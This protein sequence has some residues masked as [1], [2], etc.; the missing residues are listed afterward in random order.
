[1]MQEEINEW[2]RS[3]VYHEMF[4]KGN[5]VVPEYIEDPKKLKLDVPAWRELMVSEIFDEDET[6]VRVFGKALIPTP[7]VLRQQVD[8]A[9]ARV[10]NCVPPDG[11]DAWR[12]SGEEDHNGFE[13]MLPNFHTCGCENINAQ[14][15]AF[16]AG[17]N[18]SKKLSTALHFEGNSRMIQRKEERLLKRERLGHNNASK[19]HD[20]NRRAGHD[21]SSSLPKL[22]GLKPH[23]VTRPPP[24][25]SEEIC[26]RTIGPFD[27]E[28][29]KR[30]AL[31][32]D[33]PKLPKLSVGFH[34][35]AMVQP[36]LFSPAASALA[37]PPLALLPFASAFSPATSA[38][39]PLASLPSTLPTPSTSPPLASLPFA[40]AIA[41]PKLLSF[42]PAT[43]APP[44]LTSLPSTL[45]TPSRQ[46]ALD[47]SELVAAAPAAK[48]QRTQ[49][50]SESNRWWCN[51][52]REWP[53]PPGTQG[54]PHHD[55]LCMRRQRAD[56][57]FTNEPTPNMTVVQMLAG[58]DAAKAGRPDVRFVGPGN[59]D[60]QAI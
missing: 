27:S 11:I 59:H 55:K 12:P 30:H 20:A 47:G 6:P 35:P 54:N 24:A 43:S 50:K 53:R 32:M 10:L 36:K 29:G 7:D 42:L 46:R 49:V 38:S 5:V 31:D 22:I 21:A 15:T 14:Q 9:L 25:S 3:G 39:P 41:R 13:I 60:W 48:R 44:P 23:N 8:N 52:R 57:V 33:H 18:N 37:S 40:S 19:A 4:S 17:D 58:S 51:C 1:M 28:S 34:V 16:T 26:V 2:K 45:P 56:G